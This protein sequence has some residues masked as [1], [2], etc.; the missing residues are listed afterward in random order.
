MR[1]SDAAKSSAI[2]PKMKYMGAGYPNISPRGLIFAMTPTVISDVP[3]PNIEANN[4]GDLSKLGIPSGGTGIGGGIGI[5]VGTGV[6]VEFVP[7]PPQAASISPSETTDACVTERHLPI[8][9]S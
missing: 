2:V 9:N 4:Y 8:T 6:G 3:V 5:G 7:P 1:T